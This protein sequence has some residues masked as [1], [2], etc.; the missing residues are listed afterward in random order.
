VRIS[1]PGLP[2]EGQALRHTQIGHV[3]HTV[4]NVE[5]GSALTL[6]IRAEMFAGI[7]ASRQ[8]VA[9]R[10]GKPASRTMNIGTFVGKVLLVERERVEG[11]MTVILVRQPIGIKSCWQKA[12]ASDE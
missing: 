4:I 7:R 1:D 9:A 10:G 5:P 2:T 6:S 8:V 11:R 12:W 3:S